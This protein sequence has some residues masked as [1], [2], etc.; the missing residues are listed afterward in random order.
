MN[1][2]ERQA[3]DRGFHDGN[4]NAARDPMKYGY[5]KYSN[6]LAAYEKG[7]KFGREKWQAN[8][9][10]IQGCQDGEKN[11]PCNPEK[12]GYQGNVQAAYERGWKIGQATDRK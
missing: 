12:Y 5:E 10:L 6:L 9:A 4:K 8:Q 7:W 11:H 1:D 2:V 3:Q